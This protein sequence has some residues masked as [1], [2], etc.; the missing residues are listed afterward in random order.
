M[1]TEPKVQ[2]ELELVTDAEPDSTMSLLP[3]SPWRGRARFVGAH[4]R[5]QAPGNH[6][7]FIGK[8]TWAYCCENT[9]EGRMR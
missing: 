7:C 5:F 3:V 1:R 8:Y 6:N 4:V 9:L 2:A